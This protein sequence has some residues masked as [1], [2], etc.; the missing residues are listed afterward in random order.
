MSKRYSDKQKLAYYKKKANARGRNQVVVRG[1]GAYRAEKSKKYY[2]RY[3][4]SKAA[5]KDAWA[6]PDSVGAKIGGW[7]GHGA[8]SLLKA[9]TG[10]GDYKVENNSLLMGGMSPPEVVNASQSG[11]AIIRHRE[12][13]GDIN[14]TK[15]FTVQT[16]PINPG[17]RDTFPWLAQVASSY[18]CY[19]LRGMVFEF[20][21][22][23]SDAVLSSATSSALG[24][25]IMAT[26]YNSLST[27]FNSKIQMENHEFANSS[28]PS[29]TFYHPVECKKSLN[30]VDELYIRDG[31][32]P[33]DSDLR[34]YDL[35][36]MSIATVGMQADSGVCG[37]LWCTY[38][39]E[40]FHQRWY[41][42]FIVLTDKCQITGATQAAWF[43]T[44]ISF[45]AGSSL[46]L[47][48]GSNTILFPA[49][50]KTGKFLMHI[51]YVPTG[52]STAIVAPTVTATSG[53]T[54]DVVWCAAAGFDDNA[55]GGNANLTATTFVV[56][57]WI[58]ITAASALITFSGGT[59]ATSFADLVIT[60]VD[61]D[62]HA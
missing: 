26:Q 62:I 31:D 23:S 14:A 55:D 45:V 25:V 42:P 51:K 4:A 54:L 60:Q 38:E 58:T 43:G 7:L 5:S 16:F 8:Q 50:V 21:S 29:C 49:E 11:N 46:G 22:L 35:G 61:A 59:L 33:A 39:V 13:I 40:L 52:G 19:R 44:T 2:D 56:S 1:Q 36:K 10:F 53:C 57:R 6:A 24:A 27:T 28:K 15:E 9:I 20:K 48:I 41:A 3:R 34:L 17:M 47:N 18:E 37:E 32:I 30:P 12:Y